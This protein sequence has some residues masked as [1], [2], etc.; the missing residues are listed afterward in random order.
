MPC[1]IPVQASGYG[2]YEDSAYSV[3]NTSVT[4]VS[5]IVLM[6]VVLNVVLYIYI[7]IVVISCIVLTEAYLLASDIP[8]VQGKGNMLKK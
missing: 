5:P 1:N 6:E 8:R 4:P 2:P 3:S 7:L